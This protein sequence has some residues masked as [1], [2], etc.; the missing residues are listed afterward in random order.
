MRF[1]N[2]LLRNWP[3]CGIDIRPM[4]PTDSATDFLFAQRFDKRL[5]AFSCSVHIGYVHSP[6]CTESS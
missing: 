5:I 3:A 2:C 6:D 1:C 4:F